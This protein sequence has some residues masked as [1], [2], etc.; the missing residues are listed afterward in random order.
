MTFIPTGVRGAG[1]GMIRNIAS[2]NTAEAGA[3]HQ[4]FLNGSLSIPYRLLSLIIG[5]LK[6]SPKSALEYWA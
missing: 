5:Y 2:N 6:G 4:V 3:S 1:G